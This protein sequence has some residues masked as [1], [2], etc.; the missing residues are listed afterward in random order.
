M[1]LG[2]HVDRTVDRPDLWDGLN[3][4]HRAEAR[5][6]RRQ[7]HRVSGETEVTG[8]RFSTSW[9]LGVLGTGRLKQYT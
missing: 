4:N 3:W 2:E 1:S 7:T 5:A 6:D 9:S 8:A